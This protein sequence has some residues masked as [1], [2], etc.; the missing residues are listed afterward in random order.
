MRLTSK[1][2]AESLF[3][4]GLESQISSLSSSSQRTIL[5]RGLLSEDDEAG[6][7]EADGPKMPESENESTYSQQGDYRE[8]CLLKCLLLPLGFQNVGDQDCNYL[9]PQ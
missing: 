7:L 2:L 9:P 6:R 5:T 4:E 1:E 3:E 8:T